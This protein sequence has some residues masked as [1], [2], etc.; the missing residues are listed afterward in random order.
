MSRD[1]E[2]KSGEMNE[3]T[4]RNYY[5]GKGS[6]HWISEDQ[7]RRALELATTEWA[8]LLAD[9]D[10]PWLCWNVDDDWCL[11]QQRL[12]VSVGWTPVVGFDPRV[13]PPPLVDGA[14]L[15]D[16]NKGIDLP[17]MSMM[18][19]LEF[20]WLF[21]PRL[22]FWHSDLLVREPL[23][24]LLSEQFKALQDG[25]TAAVDL[26]LGWLRRMRGHYGRYWELVGCT[27]R[28]ASQQQYEA[29]SGWWRHPNAHPNA[30]GGRATRKRTRYMQDHGSGILIWD[31]LLGGDVLPID[32][33]PLHEGHCTR[34]GNPHYK[35]QSP[36]D[37][38]RDLSKDLTFNYDL[39]EVCTKLGLERYLPKK[40]FGCVG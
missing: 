1:T 8:R 18:F 16:F 30:L 12:V 21:A 27:T 34:I 6:W 26:R 28:A 17:T 39:G 36:N 11:V 2:K 20:A 19:P 25:Q 24:R 7:T 14:H 9:I 15:V 35:R 32:A 3:E 23:F 5:V 40:S 29:G 31:E 4:L 37:A 22:A 13:G 33:R 10:Y 38:R